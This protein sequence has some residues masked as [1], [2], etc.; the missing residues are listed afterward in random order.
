[1]SK[2]KKIKT[3][4]K[5]KSVKLKCFPIDISQD[6]IKELTNTTNIG[7]NLYNK[8][9]IYKKPSTNDEEINVTWDFEKLRQGILKTI[10]PRLYSWY[11]ENT[12]SCGNS[13]Y[14]AIES[15]S[16]IKITPNYLNSDKNVSL[17]KKVSLHSN[18][19]GITTFDC[20]CPFF[21]APYGCASEYGGKSDEVN[22]ML[23]TIKGGGIYTF[24]CL[25][26]YNLEYLVDIF[27][28][29][30][31]DSKPFYMFQLY[32]TGDNDINI[33][34]IERA[35]VCGV[36]VIM[37]TMDTGSNNH[38]GIG[39]LENQSDLTFQRNF[40]GNLFHDPVFNIKCYKEKKCVGTKDKLV[41]Q[42]VSDNLNISIDKLLSSFD[43][44]ASFDY[45]KHIQGKG[46]G[47]LNVT[48]ENSKEY[49]LSLKNIA[50]ICH[51]SKPL[52]K[53]V[54]RNI[55]NGFP[56]VA[57][58]CISVKNA[59]E[60]QKANVDGIY[61]SNHGGRFTYNSVAPLDVVYDIRVA[62]KKINKNFGVWFDGGIRNGQDIFTAYTQ[63]AEFVGVGRPIIY[64]CVLYG[65]AGVSSI[66][67]QLTFELEG[68]CK[69]CGQ[70]D[71]N[72]YEK[73]RDNVIHNK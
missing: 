71:L 63:G 58:G 57:K 67:K 27:K 22:S 66:T 59:L 24:A 62:V 28:T 25:T 6:Y 44:T 9:L 31:K 45:A 7:N 37:I 14:S 30:N 60:V 51:S 64:S 29:H 38:G 43:F 42:I 5:N 18:E 68:Q 53:Y 55:T 2:T 39:L 1:M 10:T 15:F 13:T 26:E 65:E 56:V 35:K 48:N 20:K 11:H 73:L 70:N 4:C 8:K 69:I 34:L 12:S 23:G 3:S 50:K 32:L 52:C 61:V 49:A 33:S 17:I 72:H 47:N 21:T 41:L 36:S 40:C 16:K 19:L 46:M 54:K